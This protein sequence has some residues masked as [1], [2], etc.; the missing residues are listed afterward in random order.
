MTIITLW[1]FSH[2][3]HHSQPIQK[4]SQSLEHV[5]PSFYGP[6]LPIT[7]CFNDCIV[8]FPNNTKIHKISKCNLEKDSYKSQLKHRTLV[9]A[10]PET[11]TKLELRGKYDIYIEYRTLTK[12]MIR[13]TQS[14]I[15]CQ[16]RKQLH[17]W[18]IGNIW[19]FI[20]CGFCTI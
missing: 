15:L 8:A 1:S 14:N 20:Q 7:S 4:G 10:F 13:E 17:L 16:S 11:W 18:Q 2:C 12:L 19:H 3:L 6:S 9:S 5:R